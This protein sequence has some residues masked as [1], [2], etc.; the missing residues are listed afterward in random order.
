[1]VNLSAFASV[2]VS[3]SCRPAA[4]AP[5]T[6][7]DATAVQETTSIGSSLTGGNGKK[8][9]EGGITGGE[10]C[11]MPHSGLSCRDQGTEPLHDLD[12]GFENMDEECIQYM[13]GE[14]E[15]NQG[16]IK[17]VNCKEKVGCMYCFN[18]RCMWKRPRDQ[19]CRGSDQ[20]H[21]SADACMSGVCNEGVQLNPLASLATAIT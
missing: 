7:H 3:L 20:E 8:F 15:R 12:C 16:G 2:L 18:E 17:G 21:D 4:A 6:P 11:I 5:T 14:Y 1:M 9:H 13:G 10:N 19:P